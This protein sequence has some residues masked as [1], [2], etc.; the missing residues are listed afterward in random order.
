MLL[1]V[2]LVASAQTTPVPSLHTGPVQGWLN[3]R[4][5]TQMGVSRETKLVDRWS[6]EGENLLWTRDFSGQGTPV[7][8]GDRAYC[9]T[10]RGAGPDLQE[11]LVCLDVTTGKTIWE[12]GF[13]D[14]LNDAAYERYAIGS[15][16]VDPATGNVYLQTSPGLVMGYTPNGKRLWQHSM[17]EEFGRLTF[18]NGRVGA[19]VVDDDLVIFHCVTSNWGT[20]GPGRDRLYA[21]H[22]LTGDLVWSSTPGVTPQ[23]NSFGTPLLAW[24][25]GFRVLLVGTGCGNVVCVNARTG[26][27]LWRHRISSGGVNSSV[28]VYEDRVI[29]IH[30]KENLDTSEIGRISSF[31]FG[32]EPPMSA[33]E[34]VELD[35]KSEVWRQPLEMFSSSPVLVGDTV[36]TM[37]RTGELVALNARS[38]AIKWQLKLDNEQLHA[39]PLYADGKLYVALRSGLF[40]ILKP[41]E[42]DCQI[43]Q[44]LQLEGAALGSPSLWHGRFL[45]Q[46]TKKLY[47]FGDP[48]K[49]GVAV[50]DPGAPAVPHTPGAPARLQIMPAEVLM[51]QGGKQALTLRV[52]DDKGLLVQSL[53]GSKA[54]WEHFIPPTAKV[55]AAMDGEVQDGSMVIPATARLSAGS[56]KAT[57]PGLTPAPLT[58]TMRGRVQ[59]NLPISE[60]FDSFT[61]GE[62]HAVEEGVNFSYPPLP[63]IG[64]RFKWEVREREG[65]KVLAKTLDTMLFQRATIFIGK[66]E[67][68][69]YT[70][71]ADVLSDGNRRTMSNVGLVHQ[72]YI[73]ALLGNAQEIE[74]SSTFDRI[75]YGVKFAWK[76]NLWYTLKPQV[77]VAEDGSGV[78][79]AKAWERGTPEPAEWTISLPHHQAHLHGAP[80]LYGFSLQNQKRVFID[81]VQVTAND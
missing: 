78:I 46:T 69:N 50:A 60:N 54:T 15:P 13:N 65:E 25:N 47:C 33:K 12:E 18:P 29:A 31:T 16:V 59:P 63:W 67:S 7:I 74:I 57:L 81:N 52:L 56:F 71:Q 72:R 3:W 40:Y 42:K 21:F 37:V 6:P 51:G 17:M 76:P 35:A 32:T 48:A 2:G 34:P 79:R 75:K 5:P 44:K 22:K 28:L 26:D 9:Y 77:L 39:S 19:P 73:I 70:M 80:G 66:P 38:G 68:H 64:A 49:A 43:L 8:A 23:D 55:K 11:Y 61:L 4:G 1:V 20:D 53:P 10:Y 14:F 45:L 24:H 30:G 41:G 36:Y 58:A 62:K 27:P